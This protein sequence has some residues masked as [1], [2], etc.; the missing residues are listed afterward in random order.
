MDEYKL[1]EYG[2]DPSWRV[3]VL[4]D[5]EC[6]LFFDQRAKLINYK[7]E[8]FELGEFI[9]EWD[10]EPQSH[11][12]FRACSIPCSGN[13]ETIE[14]VKVELDPKRLESFNSDTKFIQ[15]LFRSYSNVDHLILINDE[16]FSTLLN[17]QRPKDIAH[18]AFHI[19]EYELYDQ[20][21]KGEE[22]DEN[23]EKLVDQYFAS[24][25]AE[26]KK[27]ELNKICS[28]RNGR[29]KYGRL[30]IITKFR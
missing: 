26:Q 7:A 24:L 22:V 16:A 4:D 21:H 15:R 20:T 14:D 2:L 30:R 28:P 11:D 5:D 29:G 1:C 13:I 19:V 9:E 3:V 6:R 10:C 25:T 18:E 12:E 8:V 27:R 17:S 23:A